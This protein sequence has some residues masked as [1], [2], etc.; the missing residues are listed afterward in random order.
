M[1]FLKADLTEIRDAIRSKKVKAAQVV[2]FF[3]DRTKKLNPKLNAFTFINENAV[4][5]AKAIDARLEKGENC[6]ALAGVPIGIKDLLCTKGMPTTAASNILKNYVPPYNST[7]VQKLVDQGAIVLGKLNLDEFAMGSSSETSAFGIC[8]NPW[9]TDYVPGGSSGGSAAAVAARMVPASIGTD[10]GGSIRQPASFCGINGLK[11]TYGR[12]SRY[13][14]IAFASS[15]DQA[16]AMT[17]SNR[18]CALVTQIIS[19]HDAH[20]ATTASEAVPDFFSKIQG[21]VK[22]MKVGI[23]KEHFGSG[24]KPEV[25]DTV[26]KVKTFLTSQGAQ[27]VDVSLS[28]TSAAVPVYY[29]VATSEASSN[30]ARYDGVRFGYRSPQ[31]EK[32]VENLEQFYAITRGEGFGTEVKRRIMLGT[33]A[34]SSG[35]YDAYYKKSSQVRRLIRDEFTKVFSQVDVLLGPMTTDVAFKIG[36]R[37]SDPVSM[38]MN[39]AFTTATNLAGIPGMSVPVSFS[40]NGLPIGVQLMASHFQEQKLFNVAESIEKEFKAIAKVPNV[41]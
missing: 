22:G 11:P 38:Y 5:E 1:D 13:G 40:A 10:T 17:I 36:E 28:L 37:I 24:L 26:E 19:G 15:L 41:L 20:D 39:D 31:V 29:L 7:V 8:R 30:L 34:L 4:A 33:Y 35:Y 18:D 27:V 12:V 23:P 2:E 16:G 21:H 3:L 14:I 32:G 6:G 9:N 25:R